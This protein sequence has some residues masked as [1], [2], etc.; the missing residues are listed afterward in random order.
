MI[1]LFTSY[2]ESENKER[3]AEIDLCLNK[4]IKNWLIDKIFITNESNKKHRKKVKVFSKSRPMF[5]DFFNA[6]KEYSKPKDINII[7]NSDIYFDNT[8]SLLAGLYSDNLCLALSRADKVGDRFISY[9]SEYSQD[10]WIFFGKIEKEIYGDFYL[11]R[12]GCDNRIAYEIAKAGYEVRNLCK[13]ITIIHLHQSQIKT[14]IRDGMEN[15]SD[16]YK[17]INPE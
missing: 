3:Q 8:L 17:F 10:A 7:A 9:H 12:P 4:N 6:I 2:F 1:N 14:Y 5:T 13:T 15:V 16:P 11:G